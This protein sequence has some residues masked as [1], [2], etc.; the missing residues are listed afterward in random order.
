MS[1]RY[2]KVKIR[3]YPPEKF[4]ARIENN[5]EDRN[6]VNA[7]LDFCLKDTEPRYM[8]I[9]DGDE[10]DWSI[11]VTHTAP[12][13]LFSD[14]QVYKAGGK[15]DTVMTFYPETGGWHLYIPIYLDDGDPAYEFFFNYDPRRVEDGTNSAPIG[16]YKCYTELRFSDFLRCGRLALSIHLMDA[17]KLLL[18]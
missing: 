13:V 15:I 7:V 17:V 6:I 3:Y 8:E 5:E 11:M 14:S 18:V 10:M 2:R 4:L 12:I 1:L 9:G 16:M